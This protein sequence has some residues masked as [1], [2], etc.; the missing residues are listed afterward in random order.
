MAETF[1]I[2]RVQHTPQS[3]IGL[4]IV[5]KQQIYYVLDKQII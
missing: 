3:G 5:W 2:L 1:E 4:D